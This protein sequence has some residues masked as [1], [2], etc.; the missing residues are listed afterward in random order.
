LNEKRVFSDERVL[1]RI[2]ELDV[3]LVAADLTKNDERLA[4]DLDRVDRKQIP[5][6][7]IYPADPKQPAVLL[8]ELITPDDALKALNLV[9]KK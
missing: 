9:A 7:L 8:E 4:K 6:N 2:K 1:E 3:V 5:V